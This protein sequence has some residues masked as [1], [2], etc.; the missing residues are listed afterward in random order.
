MKFIAVGVSTNDNTATCDAFCKHFI[1]LTR[2]FRG[3]IPISTSNNLDQI[4]I[5]ERLMYFSH[6]TETDI[7]ETF[8]H[9]NNECGINDV[10][11]KFLVMFKSYVSH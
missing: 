11:R 10:S 9:I 3:S 7:I 6:A 5:N 8:M 4:K 1:D 2:N